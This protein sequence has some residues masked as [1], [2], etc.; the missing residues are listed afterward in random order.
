MYFTDSG[1][2]FDKELAV[3]RAERRV[4]LMTDMPVEGRYKARRTQHAFSF[5]RDLTTPCLHDTTTGGATGAGNE[6]T[7][8][9]AGIGIGTGIKTETESVIR[10]AGA[11]APAA[12]DDQA[13]T[14][15]PHHFLTTAQTVLQID[16][17]TEETGT[18]TGETGIPGTHA[19]AMSEIDETHLGGMEN[20]TGTGIGMRG[21]RGMERR[22][23]VQS[24]TQSGL[25]SGVHGRIQSPGRQ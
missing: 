22:V 2:P 15:H 3:R 20:G 18:R 23:G 19:A 12:Q 9:K 10:A 1:L 17:T 5:T 13:C 24:M 11:A 21:K 8:T 25:P 7:E 4:A 14:T 16:A 6:T